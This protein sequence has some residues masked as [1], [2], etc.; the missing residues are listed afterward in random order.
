VINPGFFGQRADAG[1]FA[2]VGPTVGANVSAD[3]FVGYVKGGI[4]NVSGKTVNQNITIGPFSITVFHDVETGEVMGGTFGLGPGVAPVGYSGAFDVTGTATI[5]DLVNWVMP[6]S[7]PA[8]SNN[9]VS[10]GGGFVIYPNKPN[11][12]MMQSVYAK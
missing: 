4:E 5:R 3:V 11:L 10:A 12:N 7:Q 2:S 8:Y 6:E 9:N 1:F